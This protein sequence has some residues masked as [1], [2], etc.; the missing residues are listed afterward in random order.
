MRLCWLYVARSSLKKKPRV[1]GGVGEVTS[2]PLYEQQHA[3]SAEWSDNMCRW[4][5][6]CLCHCLWHCH[7]HCHC[8]CICL[9]IFLCLLSVRQ[10]MKTYENMR[11]TDSRESEFGLSGNALANQNF[12]TRRKSCFSWTD[13]RRTSRQLDFYGIISW[14]L[15]PSQEFGSINR[16]RSVWAG[17]KYIT[18]RLLFDSSVTLS[19]GIIC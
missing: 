8:L 2:N 14:F 1:R 9:P 4:I 17:T 15:P 19:C 12:S 7:C 10:I 5:C 6:L 18:K 16:E 13:R 11:R 3:Q